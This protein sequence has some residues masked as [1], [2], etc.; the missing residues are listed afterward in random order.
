MDCPIDAESIGCSN[1]F[2]FVNTA[3]RNRGWEFEKME[4]GLPIERAIEISSS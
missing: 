4:I 3:S 1:K 2:T